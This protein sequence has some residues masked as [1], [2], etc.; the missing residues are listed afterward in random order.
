[1]RSDPKVRFREEATHTLVVVFLRGGADGLSMVVPTEDDA[2]YRARPLI[3]IAKGDTK[4][5]DSMFGFNA[6]MAPLHRAYDEGELL[7]VQGAGSEEDSRSHFEA[8]DYMEHGGTGAGGWL[9]RYLRNNSRAANNPLAAVALGKYSPESLRSSP[10]TVVMDSLAELSLG[11][12]AREYLDDLRDLYGAASLPWADAGTDLL[13]A[14]ERIESLHSSPYE[15]EGGA[16]YPDDAFA[17]HL[18]Q[19]AQLVKAGLGV[20]A[21][22]L[23]LAGWDS[24]VVSATLMNPLMTRLAAGLMAF[25]DDLG[26]KRENTTVVVMSEFGRRVYE[27]ASLG[28]DH[29]RGSV[30][31]VLGG[32]VRGGRVLADWPGLAEEHLEGPGDLPVRFNYRDI[33]AGIVQ[34]HLPETALNQIFPGYTL[35]PMETMY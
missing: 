6:A 17:Q 21:V 24:H 33:L 7:I 29:G 26:P 35:K 14:M 4:A 16:S 11:E 19:V 2:Y 30:M 12:D 10:A 34:R 25:Y 5:L 28:T 23:D 8:Q 27:N 15:S 32:G 9:G 22:T 31:M 3:G 20:E 18:K 13:D 1:M